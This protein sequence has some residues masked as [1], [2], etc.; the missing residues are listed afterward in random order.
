MTI[1][2]LKSL[3]RSLVGDAINYT[4]NSNASFTAQTYSDQQ[5]SA[6]IA[7][8]FKLYGTLTDKLYKEYPNIIL[9]DSGFADLPSGDLGVLHCIFNGTDLLKSSLKFEY[10]K[11][12][13]WQLVTGTPTRFIEYDGAKVRIIPKQTIIEDEDQFV[14]IGV[15]DIPPVG[16]DGDEIDSRISGNHQDHLKLAAAAYLLTIQGDQQ[17]IDLA[18]N[19]LQQFNML[20]KEKS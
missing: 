13:A 5:L 19:Y 7:H 15:V 1:G 18:N 14:T 16:V 10:M 12:P 3:I 8:A 17:N 20:I 6:S 11:N 4:P 9:T 2:Q